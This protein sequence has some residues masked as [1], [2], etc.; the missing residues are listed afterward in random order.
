MQSIPALAD[1]GYG[2]VAFVSVP[3]KKAERHGKRHQPP[4][5][6]KGHILPA[7]PE[8]AALE[9]HAP[10]GIDQRCQR[11]GPKNRLQRIGVAFSGEK[12]ARSQPHR[13]HDKIEHAGDSFQRLRS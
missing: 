1:Q 9:H 4:T 3:A 7:T 5:A 8:R 11:Q 2:S 10:Q 13:Q 12:N 6:H